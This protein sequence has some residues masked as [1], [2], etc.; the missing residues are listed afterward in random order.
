MKITRSDGVQQIRAATKRDHGEEFQPSVP[1]DKIAMSRRPKSGRHHQGQQRYER[2]INTTF[3][4]RRERKTARIRVSDRRENKREAAEGQQVGRSPKA[5]TQA[6]TELSFLPERGSRERRFHP[7]DS[8]SLQLCSDFARPTDNPSKP[9]S[10][11][12]G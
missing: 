10:C 11:R 6:G 4:E 9:V 3:F 5:V 1:L 7:T 2:E 8:N 12:P